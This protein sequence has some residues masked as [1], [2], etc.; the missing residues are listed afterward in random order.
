MGKLHMT[1]T[2]NRWGI[3]ALACFAALGVAVM[4]APASAEITEK[5]PGAQKAVEVVAAWVKAG[6]P[7]GAFTYKDLSGNDTAASFK[8]DVLPLMTKENIWGDNLPSCVSCHSG[9]TEESLHEMDAGSVKGLITG[10]DSLSAPPGVSVL[11]ASKVGATDYDWGH[12]KMRD[13]LRNNRMPP[14]VEFDIT[15]E[16]RDGPCVEVGAN[17]ATVTPGKYGCETN[18][19]GMIG[20]WVEAGAPEKD[21]VAYGGGKINFARDIMPLMTKENVWSPNTASCVSCH[22]GNTEESLHEM[23]LTT[24]KGWVT[25]AD[26]LSS[27]PGVSILGASKVGATDFNWK[28]SKMRAR[29]RDNRMPP[30]IEFDITEENRDGP[31]VLHG[32]R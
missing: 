2:A 27:P 17:G 28:K 30:G 10:A 18:A 24:Y 5:T 26:S 8:D 1:K 31:I 7:D 19:V 11:G 32:N 25:G 12:S 6:A 16:N 22:S 3:S 20:A 9:N 21:D 29:L 15:E 14:G 13:R 4:A 23:D